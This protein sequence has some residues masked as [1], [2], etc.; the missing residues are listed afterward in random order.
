MKVTRLLPPRPLEHRK[1]ALL[2][3]RRRRA[4]PD[5][6]CSRPL[7]DGH[8]APRP[9]PGDQL[10]HDLAGACVSFRDDERR[11]EVAP[12]CARIKPTPTGSAPRLPT[13]VVE[14]FTR[15]RGHGGSREPLPVEHTPEVT[16]NVIHGRAGG[17][18]RGSSQAHPYPL[19]PLRR[20]CQHRPR[21][22]SEIV[23]DPDRLVDEPDPRSAHVNSVRIVD[24]S[25]TAG[26]V[27]TVVALRDRSGVLHGASAWKTRGAALRQYMEGTDDD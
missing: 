7:R 14:P 23:T 17:M 24:Y 13:Q 10:K 27:L 4:C 21:L 20:S 16:Y 5:P 6:H 3:P 15:G 11:A 8:P 12:G 22:A 9:A 18:G 2:G 25:P 1:P 19:H 26:M